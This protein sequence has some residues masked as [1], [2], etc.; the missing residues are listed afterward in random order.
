VDRGVDGALLCPLCRVLMQ[1]RGE[2]RI[3]QGGWTQ[4]QDEGGQFLAQ[5]IR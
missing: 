1:G 4:L 5:G 2:A 3:V